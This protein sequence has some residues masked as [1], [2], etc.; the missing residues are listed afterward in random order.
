MTKKK[1]H[2][3]GDD[4][5]TSRGTAKGPH[6]VGY[7]SGAASAAPPDKGVPGPV[8]RQADRAQ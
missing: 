1:T 2:H 3:A 5:V 4:H 7:S 8:L 6:S